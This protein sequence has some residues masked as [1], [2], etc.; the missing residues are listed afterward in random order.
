VAESHKAAPGYSLA[1]LGLAV[2]GWI[3][4]TSLVS[5]SP[6]F[7][8]M[9][10][11]GVFALVYI[12]AQAVERLV[13]IILSVVDSLA[14][15]AGKELAPT[16]KAKAL[17]ALSAVPAAAAAPAG[18][19]ANAAAIEKEQARSAESDTHA[20]AFGLALGIAF[21][22]C[23]YFEVGLLKLIGVEQVPIWVDRF[24]SG[25]IVAG[26]AKPLH[27]LISKVQTSKQK[28]Q[29]AAPE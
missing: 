29:E 14:G 17:R 26:G 20:L 12:L 10:G 13:E 15:K 7:T 21:L 9:E 2:V 28:D 3:A 27:D 25:I 11:I 24:V 6:T 4:G 23:G 18:V 19:A 5:Q 1:G 16:T 8:P 22:G